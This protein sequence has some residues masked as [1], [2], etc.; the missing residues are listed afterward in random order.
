LLMLNRPVSRGKA[1]LLINLQLLYCAVSLNR[2][3]TD[4]HHDRDTPGQD[5]FLKE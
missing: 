3:L 1:F 4:I 5:D 2:G